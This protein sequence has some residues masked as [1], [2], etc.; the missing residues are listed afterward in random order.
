MVQRHEGS[1]MGRDRGIREADG[2][3]A[4]RQVG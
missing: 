3:E 2:T 1:C 4:E